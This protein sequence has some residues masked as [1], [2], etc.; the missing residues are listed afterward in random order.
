MISPQ[1]L[2]KRVTLE[3]PVITIDASSGSKRETWE[4]VPGSDN[5][6]ASVQPVSSKV[7]QQ[8]AS[9]QIVITHQIFTGIDMHP[10]RGDRVRLVGLGTY[11]LVTGFFNQAGKNKVFMIEGREVAV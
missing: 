8:Y 5:I 1:L 9:R 3:R 6:P 4:T 10:K 7:Q 2:N 11:Y